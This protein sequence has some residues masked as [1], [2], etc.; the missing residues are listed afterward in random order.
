MGPAEKWQLDAPV[1]DASWLPDAM[2]LDAPWWMPDAALG[3]GSAASTA[4]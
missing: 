2:I 1:K 4:M 3:S